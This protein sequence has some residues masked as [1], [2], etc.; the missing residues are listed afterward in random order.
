[1]V[2]MTPPTEQHWFTAPLAIA[3]RL[4]G[5]ARR[6]I[7]GQTGPR[8]PALR[9]CVEPGSAQPVARLLA[10]AQWTKLSAVVMSAVTGTE[11]AERLH[12]AAAEQLSA[13]SY[14]LQ[15][16]LA[17]LSS[18]M[19]A[20]MVQQSA[21]LVAMWPAVPTDTASSTFRPALAA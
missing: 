21:S 2:A 20:A 9:R 4:V 16:L 19:P 18:V 7:V 17:E 11:Q 10:D 6:A 13:A 14:A 15:T 5:V 3:S 1:M 8:R 12:L